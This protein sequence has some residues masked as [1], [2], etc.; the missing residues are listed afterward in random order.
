[1]GIRTRIKR[2]TRRRDF[3]PNL[4]VNLSP[5]MLR[6]LFAA[7]QV[8]PRVFLEIGA[9][10]GSDTNRMLENFPEVS[11]YCFEPE[12][13]AIALFR[14]NVASNRAHLQEIAVGA[15]DEKRT[16]YR[17]G[18]SP[19]GSESEFPD[20]WHLSG[21]LR[22]PLKHLTVHPWCRFSE[23][24]TF[25]VDVRRLDGW[26]AANGIEAIDFIWADVQGAEL[27]LIAGGIRTLANTRFFYT[28]Y[29]D[30]ELYRGQGTLRD[31]LDALPMFSVHTVFR[32]D[33]LLINNSL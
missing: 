14:K 5:E 1:M 8:N 20:G 4:A 24:A 13:R 30:Q 9:N 21:S 31:I 17:S 10:D 6:G 28:E 25:K 15:A 32:H 11:I 2:L 23:D 22:E 7:H 29:S 16:F 26:T 3:T 19:P 27:D 33:V 12:P 18:G